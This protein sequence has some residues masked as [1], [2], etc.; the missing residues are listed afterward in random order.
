MKI[1]IT[2]NAGSGKTTLAKR[3]GELLSI[4]VFHLDSVVWQPG[5]TITPEADRRRQETQLCQ[6]DSWII[7]GVSKTARSQADVTVFL[8]TNRSRCLI[9]CLQRNLPYLFKSRPELPEQCPEILIIP[10]LVRIIWQ[11][12]TKAKPSILASLNSTDLVIK[13]NTPIDETI[14]IVLKC[15]TSY[16]GK[17]PMK[18]RVTT[19]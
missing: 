13:D 14:E 9:R 11:F 5:W 1:H 16:N 19:N 8:D 12:P 2:G 18:D 4:P 3:L 17:S 6:L 10:A 15:V 7:E